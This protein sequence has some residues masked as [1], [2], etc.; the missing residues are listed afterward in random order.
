VLNEKAGAFLFGIAKNVFMEWLRKRRNDALRLVPYET[1]PQVS[2]IAFESCIFRA[3]VLAEKQVAELNAAIEGLPDYLREII[4]LL[5]L[6]G[7]T[8]D[9][10][11]RQIGVFRR[12]VYYR[13]KEALEQMRGSLA[14]R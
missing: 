2:G 8:H 7:L 4:Q 6:Q 3:S 11:A 14:L 1:T 5:Y 9:E 13:E 10:A 12:T